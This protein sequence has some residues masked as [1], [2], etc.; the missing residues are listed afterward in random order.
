[1]TLSISCHCP[2]SVPSHDGSK[3]N[4]KS[5]DEWQIAYPWMELTDCGEKGLKCTVCKQAKMNN[6]WAFEGTPNLQKS[7]LQRHCISNDHVAAEKNAGSVEC[8]GV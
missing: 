8:F 5:I 1:M 4:Q 7:S 2:H 6:V 3:V